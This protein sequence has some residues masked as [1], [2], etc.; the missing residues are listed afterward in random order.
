MKM[1]TLTPRQIEQI[2]D[3]LRKVGDFQIIEQAKIESGQITDKGL[4]QLV[5][6]VDL[7]SE[8]M[9]V[10]AL[11]ALTPEAGFVTEEN[12]AERGSEDLYWVIDPL[13]G[14]TNYL[15]QHEQFAISIALIQGNDTLYG[16]VYLPRNQELFTATP[17]GAFLNGKSISVSMR[18]T[19]EETLIATGFPY[20]TFEE[21]DDYLAVLKILMQRT[22]GLRRMGSAAIDLCYTANGKFDGFF[23]L[24]LSPWDVAAGA[25]IIQ[26]A[27]GMVT[28]FYEGDDPIFGKSIVAGNPTIRALLQEILQQYH[29]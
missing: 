29:F 3:L 22:K 10:S 21:I 24:N 16:G 17:E 19:L 11:Q 1:D 27:G 4:N 9:L 6:Y 7:E 15:F 18:H 8:R 14:T 20:Y 25:Y 5:S 13:D 2:A 12:T 28:G 23:E 26:Q